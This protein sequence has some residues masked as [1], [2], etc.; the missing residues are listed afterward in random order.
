MDKREKRKSYKTWND[1]VKNEFCRAARKNLIQLYNQLLVPVGISGG[2]QAPPAT[3]TIHMPVSSPTL[4]TYHGIFTEK[5]HCETVIYDKIYAEMLITFKN[6]VQSAVIGT[7]NALRG[8]QLVCP[9]AS[10][11]LCST[12]MVV[13]GITPGTKFDKIYNDYVF[14]QVILQSPENMQKLVGED[15]WT[16][17]LS[18]SP[19]SQPLVW[20]DLPTW[21]DQSK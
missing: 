2:D 6:D 13:L 7:E 18:L 17:Y 15:A 4:K 16:I 14:P 1:S 12:I 8:E 3:M 19:D 21:L 9:T 5:K 11:F 20:R 10:C